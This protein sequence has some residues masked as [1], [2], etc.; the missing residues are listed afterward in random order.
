MAKQAVFI[1][2][3]GCLLSESGNVS[4]EYYEAIYQISQYVLR[5]VLG[6]GPLI[7]IFTEENQSFAEVLCHFLGIVNYPVIIEDGAFLFNPTTKQK[8][9]H[10]ALN[11]SVRKNFEKI[12]RKIIIP[13]LEEYPSLCLRSDKSAGFVLEKQE[14]ALSTESVYRKLREELR[15][16]ILRE[17]IKI[18]FSKNR[19]Y[20]NPPGI[21]KGAGLKFLAERENIDLKNS[22][23]IGIGREDISCFRQ[24]GIVGCPS[25]ADEKCRFFVK[26]KRGMVSLKSFALGT[27]DV[28]SY[29]FGQ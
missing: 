26:K 13:F 17:R 1:N 3:I 24:T 27:L 29:Y 22:L 21:N 6:E 18:Y 7:Y 4:A 20:I 5:G 28:I 19:I 10:P 14:S 11:Y 25:N 2:P 12:K 16:R 15:K 9:A 8:E 23:T